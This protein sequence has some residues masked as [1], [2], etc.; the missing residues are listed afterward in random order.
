MGV[1][2]APAGRD[3]ESRRVDLA[4]SCAGLALDLRDA[5][6]IDREVAGPRRR[7]G[8]VAEG[9]ATEK[10][11]VHAISRNRFASHLITESH[12]HWM[13]QLGWASGEASGCCM[14]LAVSVIALC[15]VCAAHP[16][17]GEPMNL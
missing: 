7:T 6:A 17:R 12:T 10:G 4:L 16:A 2:V 13:G 15:S 14:R 11:G 3:D 8:A 9:A 1:H 5:I